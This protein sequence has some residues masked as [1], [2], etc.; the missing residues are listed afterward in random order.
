MG[1]RV[2][3][4]G[5]G[6]LNACGN[7]VETSWEAVLA[8]R[9]GIGLITRFDP[10]ILDLP[11]RIAAELKDFD[12]S[13]WFQRRD[14][15]KLDLMTQYGMAAAMMA[16]KD[17]GLEDANGLEPERAGAIIGTG[18]GGLDT[19]EQTHT[20]IMEKGP[21][22]VSPY[23]VPK[24]MANAIAGNLSIRFNLKGPN[25]ITAS[26]CASS[27]HAMALAFRSI[28][29]GECDLCIS[30]GAEATI[31]SMGMAGFNSMRAMSTR[32]DEP[33]RAS[34]PFD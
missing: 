13:V 25:F 34:R 32:N 31:T 28:R 1:R 8:G 9:S 18:I 33:E 10:N 23:F 19:I 2:A 14:L 20:T 4:S 17:A 15:K 29:D 12:P 30:G 21:L 11:C 22:R 6:T 5:L 26:A 27:N 16:W 3:V 24:M 7:D